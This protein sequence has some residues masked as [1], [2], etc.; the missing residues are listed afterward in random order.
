M[1]AANCS[2]SSG[3]GS[4]SSALAWPAD[5]TPAATRRWTGTGSLS[6]L[7]VLEMTGR[8]RPSRDGQL[9]LGD[10]EL[11]EQ[12]LVGGRLFQR[13]QV[14]PM[15]VLQQRVPEQVGVLGA[16]DDRRDGADAGP[17]RGPPTALT[18]HQ[19]VA[20]ARHIAD[21][22]RLQQAELADRVGELDQGVLVEHRPRVPRV[23][24]DLV[25]RDIDVARARGL[26]DASTFWSG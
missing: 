23:A 13:V 24:P 22:D 20:A 1:R 17:L 18:H 3:S 11:L 8:L 12:L 4:D 14:G 5:N 25:D 7:M 6:S 26:D 15:D 9:L 19:L 2:W 21:D 10:V 16:P